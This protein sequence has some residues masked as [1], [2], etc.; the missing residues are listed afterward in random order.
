M[1]S[2][3]HPIA[4]V[5]FFS[6]TMSTVLRQVPLSVERDYYHALRPHVATIRS[7]V[8][9]PPLIHSASALLP[10][11]PHNMRTPACANLSNAELKR[12][13][14]PVHAALVRL[15][16]YFSLFNFAYSVFQMVHYAKDSDSPSDPNVK[17]FV[18]SFLHAAGYLQDPFVPKEWGTRWYRRDKAHH[19]RNNVRPLLSPFLF[20]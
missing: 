9:P 7:L 17:A 13:L 2:A 11:I 19:A 1:P 15:F 14:V 12:Q 10:P 4:L 8:Q 5:S 18:T 20:F 16:P 6:P 3:A